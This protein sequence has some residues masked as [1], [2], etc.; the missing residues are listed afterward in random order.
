MARGGN[1]P[2][3]YYKDPEKTA[4]TFVEV[5]GKRYSVPGDFARSSSTAR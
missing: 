4:A 3:G 2:L 5:D 1:V